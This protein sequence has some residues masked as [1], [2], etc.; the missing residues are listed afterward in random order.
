LCDRC[1]VIGVSTIKDLVAKASDIGVKR[2]ST[3]MIAFILSQVGTTVYP[4]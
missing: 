3:S 2:H 1:T 4:L